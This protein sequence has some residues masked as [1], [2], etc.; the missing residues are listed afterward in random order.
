[1]NSTKYRNFLKFNLLFLSLALSTGQVVAQTEAF[2]TLKCELRN[3]V[4]PPSLMQ[5]DG[6]N[7][8]AVAMAEQ[9]EKDWYAFQLPKGRPAFYYLGSTPQNI[10]PIIL[11]E[12]EEVLV[13]GLCNAMR[14]N[15]ISRSPINEAYLWIKQEMD[16]L[17]QESM[18]LARTYTGSPETARE[19]VLEDIRAVDERKL[20]LMDTA[21]QIHPMLRHV[22]GMNTYLSYQ[23]HGQDYENELDYFANEYFR[24]ADFSDSTYN[25]LPWIYEG[26]RNYATTLLSVRMPSEQQQQYTD[27]LLQQLETGSLAHRLALTGVIAV[28]QSKKSESFA[29]FAEQF[30]EAF[31]KTAPGDAA[32]L[33][34]QLDQAQQVSL[35]SYA[36]DFAQKTPNGDSLNLSSLRGKVVLIDFW[37]SWCGPCRRE[38]PNVV[39]VYEKY[40]D[41]GFEILGVS[42]DRKEDAWLKAI[43]DDELAWLHVSDLKGWQNQAAQLYGV[44]SIPETV[45][46]DA[47]GRIIAKGLRAAALEAKLAALFGE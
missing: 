3:C 25:D 2:I 40:K 1:M 10:L 24:F 11:G 38:N 17:H 43:A 28:H 15:V 13:Q 29:H 45:L 23:H 42:L 26:F 8:T 9:T 46:L 19:Q 36:P 37:A 47:E 32:Q 12:E 41:K 16:G 27:T 7:F 14:G 4:E 30:I 20:S 34:A 39:K 21:K 6:L 33:Q 18:A 35:G 22:V 31:Q 5:F 44:R